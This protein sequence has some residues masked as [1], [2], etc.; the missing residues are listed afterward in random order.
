[1]TITIVLPCLLFGIEVA[2][3]RKV[4]GSPKDQAA[5]ETILEMAK[6]VRR[7]VKGFLDIYY[8]YR[9]LYE[10]KP[11]VGQPVIGRRLDLF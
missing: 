11:N 2:I 1:M 4:N 3:F 5:R 6:I 7:R 10:R 8:G 9:I